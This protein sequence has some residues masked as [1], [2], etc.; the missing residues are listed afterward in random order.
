M[1]SRNSGAA[2][3]SGKPPNVIIVFADDLGYGDLGCYGA[4]LI[5]TP[6]L[7]QMARDGVRLTS[8]YAAAPVCSPS[9]AALLTGRYPVR[10]GMPN[11]TGPGGNNFLP[12]SEITIGN[13]LKA[14]GY[15]TMAVGKWHLGHQR[16]ELLPTGRGFD[17][18]FGLPYSNDMRKPFVQSDEPLKLY[19][20]E[21]PIE[22]PVNQDTLTERYSEESVRF[23]RDCG[24]QPFFLYLAHSMP[25]LPIHTSERFRGQSEGGLYGDVI[26]TIDWSVGQIC[27]T[28][29][30][31]GIEKDT[32]LIFTSDNGPWLNLP[33]RMLQEGN[34]RWH[35]G[36]P[37]PFRGAKG[38]T[39]EGGVRVPMIAAWPGQIPAG[40]ESSAL[41]TTMDLFP[42]I[43]HA[44]GGEA[45]A[46]RTLDGRDILPLLREGGP[47]PHER[48]YY[49]LADKL[50]AV[51][52][53]DWKLRRAG[54]EPET[55]L[56]H[57]GRDPGERYNVAEQHPEIV[58]RLQD[59]MKA[60]ESE[61]RRP[62]RSA[63]IPVRVAWEGGWRCSIGLISRI[64][65]I[66][67][68]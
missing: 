3:E 20:N 24:G 65:P 7:D 21:E 6:Q 14:R 58:Q 67:P 64:G 43:C 13:V 1:L 47:S 41:A 61:V 68:R 57:L 35:T 36:S 53:G 23:I 39:Y 29:R 28:L 38:T 9:R 66:S 4:P 30:A 63:D 18:W 44:A 2:G 25:H 27:A 55:E 59:A 15:R 11:N 5:R 40:S 50:E 16:P 32:L 60:F 26:A 42:S 62:E 51:R 49:F 37:G 12:E 45:P 48:F 31:Q 46:D 33:D 22:F 54:K 17:A 56:F 19:R 8:F 52:E 10:C 34:E